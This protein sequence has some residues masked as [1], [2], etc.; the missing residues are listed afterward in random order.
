MGEAALAIQPEVE[1]LWEYTPGGATLERFHESDEF[2]RLVIGPVGSGKSTACCM[3]LFRRAQEQAPAFDGL[4]KTRWGIV[5]NTYRELKDTTLKTWLEWFD[6]SV[7]GRFNNTDMVHHI[8]YGDV[9]MEVMF[10]ALD[11]P[12]D[13][14]KL[15][16]L[17]L[18]GVWFNEAREIPKAL[19]DAADDRVERYP[20]DKDGGCTWSGLIL[21]TNPPDEDHWIF[22]L[23]EE[24][25]PEGWDVFKQPGG[26][27]EIAE[28]FYPNP[29]AENMRD[30]RTGRPGVPVDY[31][32]KRMRGKGKDHIRVYYCAQY[33][34]VMAGKPIYPDYVD[35]VHCAHE[36]LRPV[37]G[38]PIYVGIDFGLTPAATLGQRLA[39]GRWI[40]FDEVVTE[41]M[42]ATRFAKVLGPVLRGDYGGFEFIIT[43]DPAGEQR[44]QTDEKTVFQILRANGINAHPAPTNDF[45]L[46][47]DAVAES[48]RRMIDGKPGHIVSPKCKMLRKGLAGGYGLKRLKV[49][50]EERYQEKPDKNVYSH[51]CEGHQYMMLGA[52]EGRKVVESAA[53]ANVKTKPTR[54]IRPKRR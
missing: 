2:H 20:S 54:N 24:D 22:K 32:T 46:R 47:V 28:K 27:I 9:D 13:V 12:D 44:A 26:L 11:R 19:V 37:K 48:F 25:R 33:G 7:F 39:N 17:E 31:Y 51:V 34:F 10:R 16:S 52:G 38:L 35:A 30:P 23:A 50:G 18:T 53:S 14:K 8:R 15:L 5:R 1:T 45:T 43:G 40:T 21:D 29:L 6:E 49:A 3:E 4:R 41:D 36:D 42:G